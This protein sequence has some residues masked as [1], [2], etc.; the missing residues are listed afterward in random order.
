M[1]NPLGL[2]RIETLRMNTHHAALFGFLLFGASF[3]CSAETVMKWD[4][5]VIDDV[6]RAPIQGVRIDCR[7]IDHIAFQKETVGSC[8]TTEAGRCSI[9]SVASGSN[10]WL[11]PS[12]MSAKCIPAAAGYSTEFKYSSRKTSDSAET[13]FQLQAGPKTRYSVKSYL[14]DIELQDDELEVTARITTSKIVGPKSGIT[15]QVRA[16]VNKRTGSLQYQ[17]LV[18]V[19]YE[20]SG[21]RTYQ[22]A[23]AGT[24]AGP[25]ELNLYSVAKDVECSGKS[26]GSRQC[27]YLE[28]VGIDVSNQLFDDLVK[29]SQDGAETDFRLRIR[30]KT[31]VAETIGIPHVAFAA[32]ALRAQDFKSRLTK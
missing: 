5:V 3:Q 4:Y 22:L 26:T 1:E 12:N 17:L 18:R 30:S 28:V 13:T 7:F 6:T 9:E 19:S 29:M 32:I 15:S 23:T 27:Q 21:F 31:D 20:D 16:F 8:T 10:S 25:I 14:A 24:E 2:N 11:S